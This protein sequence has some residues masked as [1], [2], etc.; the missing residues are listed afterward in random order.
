MV[1]SGFVTSFV[2]E[3][4]TA[5]DRQICRSVAVDA[6][7]HLASIA[8]GSLTQLDRSSVRYSEILLVVD[9]NL[10]SKD[11]SYPQQIV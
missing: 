9:R 8:N 11:R 6:C 7:R 2:T 4:A 10:Q 3:M 1:V 5:T